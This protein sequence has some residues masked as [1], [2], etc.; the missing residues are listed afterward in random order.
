MINVEQI[1]GVHIRMPIVDEFAGLRKD[2]QSTVS[3][4]IEKTKS[5]L[6]L[7]ELTIRIK[8]KPEAVIPDHAHA[9]WTY[10]PESVV[11]KL[12]PNFPDKEQLLKTELPRAVSHELH[13]AARKKALPTEKR[14]LGVGLISEGLATQFET[15]VWGGKPSAWATALTPD[16]IQTLLRTFIKEQSN[17]EY[18]DARWFFGTK[19]LPRWTGYTIGVYLVQEYLKLHPGET[20]ASLVSTP[21]AVILDSLKG[22]ILRSKSEE[23][24]KR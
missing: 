5:F 15:E 7:H 21:S 17:A 6:P 24:H 22:T 19:D 10:S 8:N 11:I 3:M 23:K 16:Q 4:A 13:H 1:E 2:I 14:T 18:D 20:A 9:G 12:N